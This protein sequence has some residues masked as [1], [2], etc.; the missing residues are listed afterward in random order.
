M[1]SKRWRFFVEDILKA[2]EDIHSFVGDDSFEDFS[3]N[4]LLLAAVERKF[5]II[6]EAAR[7]IPSHIKDS[8]PLVPWRK[9]AD[10]R[11]I[12]AH[13][14]WGVNQRTL[15]DTVQHDLPPLIP[16]LQK[17]LKETSD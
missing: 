14:Y 7:H 4:D 1:S 9:M 16:L 13:L 2:I 3:H 12:V 5:M 17:I 6:G 8:Y 15:W 10:M 11:N